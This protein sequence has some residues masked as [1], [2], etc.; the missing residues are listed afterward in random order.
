M[1]NAKCGTTQDDQLM[2][3][4]YKKHVD[5]DCVNMWNQGKIQLKAKYSLTL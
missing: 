3:K 4:M 1:G 2:S 5:D